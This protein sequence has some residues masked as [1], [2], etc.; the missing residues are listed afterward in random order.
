[1]GI[2]RRQHPRSSAQPPKDTDPS[3][4]WPASGLAV[5]HGD[6]LK[7]GEAIEGF[8]TLFTPEA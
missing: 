8:K 1:M 2:R 4:R 3:Q 6:G 7:G 5:V